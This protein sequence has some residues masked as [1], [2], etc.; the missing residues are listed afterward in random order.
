MRSICSRQRLIH[1]TIA[2]SLFPTVRSPAGRSRTSRFIKNV[3]S[4]CRWASITQPAWIKLR[5]VLQQAA[6]S[7]RD[8]MLSGEGR[9]YQIALGDLGDS[10]VGWTVRFWTRAENFWSVK[11]ALTRAVKQNLD[12]AGIGIPF[13]QMDIHLHGDE[14]ENDGRIK[15]RLRQ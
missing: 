13:P 11:E 9:G 7:L 3:A 4:T 12:E 2:G 8:Q 5:E 10:A 1:P 6:E 15:P 14:S